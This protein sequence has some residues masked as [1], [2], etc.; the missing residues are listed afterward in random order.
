MEQGLSSRLS[1]DMTG[2]FFYK[3]QS[4]YKQDRF[5]YI[6]LKPAAATQP[7]QDRRDGNRRE[8]NSWTVLRYSNK[9]LRDG[10]TNYPKVLQDQ[11]WYIDY[12][13]WWYIIYG[14]I[15]PTTHHPV[16]FAAMENEGKSKVREPRPVR[17]RLLMPRKRKLST[18]HRR[19]LR[20]ISS[21]AVKL[22]YPRI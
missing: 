15:L 4:I 18:D 3:D 20:A 6:L 1:F 5:R 10:N 7:G 22:V 13:C 11:K 9:Q 12:R 17:R 21:W 14:L 16:I 8:K 19:Y 2:R